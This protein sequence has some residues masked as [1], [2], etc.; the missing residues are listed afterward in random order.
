MLTNQ[1][2]VQTSNANI[3]SLK[4]DY[5]IA[6][7]FV[8]KLNILN[9][10]LCIPYNDID[11][12]FITKSWRHSN[13]SDSLIDCQD[14]NVLRDDRSCSKGGGVLLLYKCSLKVIQHI[15]YSTYNKRLKY[16]SLY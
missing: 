11:L 8:N 2:Q 15:S 3:S 4:I 16:I 10:F 6:R 14:F 13:I 5:F 7:S 9:S 12:V 1:N